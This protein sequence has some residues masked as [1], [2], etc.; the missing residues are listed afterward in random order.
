M[1]ATALP[2]AAKST[3]HAVREGLADIRDRVSEMEALPDW[4][5]IAPD[6]NKLA[7]DWNKLAEIPG[8][9]MDRAT[10]RKRRRPAWPLIALGV[11][12]VI[13]IAAAI[14]MFMMNRTSMDHFADEL[15]SDVDTPWTPG[16]STTKTASNNTVGTFPASDPI[17]SP[18][19][20]SIGG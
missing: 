4:D 1:T 2:P 17:P 13:G 19:S 11:V 6:W 8:D 12:A 5:K 10:G 16:T 15:E 18:M 7:P 14:A 20:P 9:L 3:I